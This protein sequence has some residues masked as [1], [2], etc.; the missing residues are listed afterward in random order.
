MRLLEIR[1]DPVAHFMPT[2]P[3]PGGSLLFNAGPPGL[4]PEL[5]EM[6]MRPITNLSLSKRRGEDADGRPTKKPR[7][8]GSVN[9]DGDEI[10]VAR[11]AASIARSIGP[12]SDIM[13]GAGGDIDFGGMEGG[14][15]IEDFQMDVDLQ[16]DVSGEFGQ[17]NLATSKGGDDTR[18]STPAADLAEEL[19]TYADVNC[20]IA[21]FD[22]RPTQSQS[23][24][25]LP[26]EEQT[27]GDEVDQKKGY[28]KNT[29]KALSILRK[30]LDPATNLEGGEKVLSFASLSEKVC[31]LLD[32]LVVPEDHSFSQASRR[33][34]S[35]FFFEL[36]VLGTRDCIKISQAGPFENIEIRGKDKLWEHKI[37]QASA[38]PSLA[39]SM[40][41]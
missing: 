8:D 14:P 34:A 9:G 20:P 10:E 11:R 26:Q 19:E 5:A 22:V 16:L 17:D 40:G 6:F 24:Q 21:T 32:H 13:P 35:S 2:K 29:V 15:G 7:V 4:A 12:G 38:A 18:L 23:I 33:A 3:G 27:G 28:S 39:S 25:G 41:L 36:L 1:A 31:M 37:R 30:E